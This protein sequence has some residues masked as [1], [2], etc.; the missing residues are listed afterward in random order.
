MIKDVI[1]HDPAARHIR[2]IAIV[3]PPG[4]PE[5][6]FRAF[7]IA[8]DPF[9]PKLP[10]KKALNDPLEKHRQFDCSWE[11]VR[12]RYRTCAE[13]SDEFK[14][15]LASPSDSGVA[16]WGDEEMTYRLERCIYTFFVSGLSVIESFGFCLYFLG[17]ALR[18]N[19]FPHVSKPPKITLET[20]CKAF[21][22]AFPT[23]AMATRLAALLQKPEFKKI[24]AFRNILA[25]RVSGR[26]RV[27]VSVTGQTYVQ[28]ES[29][30]VPGST[31]T[32]AFGEEMLHGLLDEIAGMVT[33]LVT[34]A[35]EFA[36]N[37]RPMK[38]GP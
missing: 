28:Q 30:H 7:G 1:N 38:A 3:M 8:A 24:T 6:E 19:D 25:H 12:Y 31:G 11:A 37:S 22:A 29:W 27:R 2:G 4:F 35:R 20:T 32:L 33:P 36:E 21:A 13:C 9:F 17:N 15:V 5:A 14:A 10:S 26:L 23:A 16:G 34:A 18:P